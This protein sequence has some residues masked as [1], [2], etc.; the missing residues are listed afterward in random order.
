ML[1]EIT[2]EELK[3]EYPDGIPAAF[4]PTCLATLIKT[5]SSSMMKLILNRREVPPPQLGTR[6]ASHATQMDDSPLSPS[7]ENPAPVI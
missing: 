2:K 6:S 1:G 5:K 7:A 4:N 3:K